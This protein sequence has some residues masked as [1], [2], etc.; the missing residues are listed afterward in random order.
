MTSKRPVVLTIAGSDPS[1]G[2]GIQ[3]D[4]KTFHQHGVYGM[5]AITLLTVQNTMRVSRVVPMEPGLVAEQIAA[6]LEDIPPDA[7][8]LGALGSA[9]IV[10]AVAEALRDYRGPIV[11]DPVMVSKHGHA[12]IDD[13]AVEAC[14]TLLFPRAELVTPNVPEALR[15]LPTESERGASQGE[16]AK[17]LARTFSVNVLLKGGHLE[18]ARAVDILATKSGDLAHFSAP[19]IDTTHTHG[20]GCTFAAAIAARLAQGLLLEE[21]IQHAKEWLTRALREAPQLG[22]GIGP[23]SHFA[24]LND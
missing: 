21:A 20:T 12:L 16:M 9:S 8:K 1:G 4:L 19:R 18:G 5:S 6:C 15:L 14:T 2:A 24:S 11:I 10:R 22:L 23:V 17:S 3:A 7:I 13:D